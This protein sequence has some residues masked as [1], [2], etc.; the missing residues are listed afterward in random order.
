MYVCS[1]RAITESQV[2]AA[3]ARG[4]RTV[5]ELIQAFGLD[6][7]SCCGRCERD[8]QALADDSA[9]RAPVSLTWSRAVGRSLA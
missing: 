7:P 6:D 5:P 9:D 4:M 3:V 1:C 8:L 2:R